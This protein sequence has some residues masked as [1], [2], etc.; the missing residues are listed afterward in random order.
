MN[1]RF[2][3]CVYSLILFSPVAFARGG[4][5]GSLIIAGVILFFM[6]AFLLW[7]WFDLPSQ[8]INVIFGRNR[9]DGIGGTIWGIFLVSSPFVVIVPILLAPKESMA[10]AVFFTLVA[11]LVIINFVVVFHERN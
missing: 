1:K 6:P 10:E 7:L 2:V 5:I 3:I 8:V 9:R 11:S 4:D